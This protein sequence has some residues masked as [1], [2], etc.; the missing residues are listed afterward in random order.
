M[1]DFNPRHTLSSSPTETQC[2]KQ[3]QFTLDFDLFMELLS[4]HT[5]IAREL[6]RAPIFGDM[7]PDVPAYEI[8]GWGVHFTDTYMS[9]D[10]KR[11]SCIY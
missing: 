3:D 11:V 8:S 1:R 9:K 4:N 6:K 2:S 5:S 10:I 7:D